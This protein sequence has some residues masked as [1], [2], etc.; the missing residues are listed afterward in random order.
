MNNDTTIVGLDVHKAT[1]TA[2]VLPKGEEKISEVKTIENTPQAVKQLVDRLAAKGPVQ[3]VYEAGPCGYEAQRQLA[4]MKLPCAVIAPALTP[5]KPGDRVKTDRRDAEKLARFYRAGE[6]TVIRVPNREE[7]AARD[8]VRVREDALED[9]MRARHRL[10]KFFLRQ[11]RI[12]QGANAWGV[13]HR[14]WLNQ[15]RFEWDSLQKSFEGFMRAFN[16]AEDRLSELDRHIE[17]LAQ[18]EPYKTPVRYLECFRGIKTLTA[19]TLIVEVMDFKRFERAP[20]FM[21]F[22]GMTSAEYSSGPKVRRF[23]ITKAGNS[24]IRR[25]LVEAAWHYRHQSPNSAAV[26]ERRKECPSD[27]L[28]IARKADSRLS[29]RFFRLV[30]R[31]KPSQVAVVAVARELSGFIWAMAKHFPQNTQS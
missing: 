6:L 31:G 1:I 25:V 23:S 15:Q 30:S 29:K 12:F 18:K 21:G 7:E 13:R 5:R 22:T 14:Q 2:A 24:H 8:L 27:V 10:S 26:R 9:R 4:L 20:S 11:G 19:M 3:F 17:E 16:E 28:Q